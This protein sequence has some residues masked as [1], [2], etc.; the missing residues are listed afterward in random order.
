MRRF[1]LEGLRQSLNI[2]LG[3]IPICFNAVYSTSYAPVPVT[4][5]AVTAGRW[6]VVGTTGVKPPP[7][8]AFSFTRIDSQRVLLFGGRQRRQRVN[9]AYILDLEMRVCSR[10]RF[11]VHI[12][13]YCTK[14]HFR[15]FVCCI[16]VCKHKCVL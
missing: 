10:E 2:L 11:W 7:C 5:T 15:L 13:L 12:L 4:C 3:S 1:H 6:R 16:S 9:D 14:Q 8:A